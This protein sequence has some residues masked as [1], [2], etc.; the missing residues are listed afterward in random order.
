LSQENQEFKANQGYI[1]RPCLKQN[2]TKLKKP[3]NKLQQ[4]SKNPKKLI[5]IKSTHLPFHRDTQLFLFWLILDPRH[6]LA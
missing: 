3:Q 5:L 4:T 2:K 1:A 6:F